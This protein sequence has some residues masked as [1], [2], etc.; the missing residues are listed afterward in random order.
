MHKRKNGM[1]FVSSLLIGALAAVP[2]ETLA[3]QH[4][5]QSGNS[6]GRRQYYCP[7]A[8]SPQNPCPPAP[9]GANSSG[10]MLTIPSDSSSNANDSDPNSPSSDDAN[11][12]AT[13]NNEQGDPLSQNQTEIP[14]NQPDA[15]VA[16]AFQDFDTAGTPLLN[17]PGMAGDF[18]GFVNTSNFFAGPGF[19]PITTSNFGTVL[20]GLASNDLGSTF[21]VTLPQGLI[22][23]GFQL[24]QD[25]TAIF[26]SGTGQIDFSSLDD[27]E[28]AA[29]STFLGQQ[30]SQQ[31]GRSVSLPDGELKNLNANNGPGGADLGLTGSVLVGGFAQGINITLPRTGNQVSRYKISDQTSPIPRDRILFSY[32]GFNSVP[33]SGGTVDVQRMVPG[34]EKTFNSGDSSIEVRMPF[35]STLDHDQIINGNGVLMGGTATQLGNLSFTLKQLVAQGENSAISTGLILELPTAEDIIYS[36]AVTEIQRAS[37]SVQLSPFIGGLVTPTERTFFQAFGQIAFDTNGETVV[38]TDRTLGGNGVGRLQ[39]PT[40]LFADLQAG[41]WAYRN[42]DAFRL[43]ELSGIAGLLE[44]HFNQALQ[45]TD[46]MT[47]LVGGNTYTFGSRDKIAVANLTA[48][49]TFE[50]GK[51][52]TLTCA[53]VIPL[54]DRDRQFDNEFQVLYSHYLDKRGSGMRVPSPR[55]SFR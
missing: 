21:S 52:S 41:V 27:G 54:T 43:S 12:Q 42:E 45:K 44:I 32:S 11:S 31:L 1:R 33:F 34:F 7:P 19:A 4:S 30:A 2:C 35:A 51:Q 50:F 23:G 20:D 22:G 46:S 3:Q 48:G 5:R 47:A 6:A 40:T 14:S 55:R 37:E 13:T 8:Q 28:R 9:L 38:V 24:T 25:V 49:S 29:L 39:D 10:E 17:P 16:Q 53:Y 26:D 15:Q 36:N 18:L